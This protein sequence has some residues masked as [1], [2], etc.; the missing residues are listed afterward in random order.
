[1]VISLVSSGVGGTDS[2]T[3]VGGTDSLTADAKLLLGFSS[4]G[5]KPLADKENS[6]EQ[7]SRIIELR[8][9]TNGFLHMRKQRRRSASLLSLQI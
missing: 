2:L 9:E 8:H 7:I 6:E 3:G 4:D 5:W 1:M